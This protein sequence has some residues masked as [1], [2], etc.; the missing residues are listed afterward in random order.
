MKKKLKETDLSTLAMK[1]RFLT[2]AL[3]LR[4]HMPNFSKKSDLHA[5][6]LIC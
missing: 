3:K 2:V 5:I 1:L 6:T 4:F